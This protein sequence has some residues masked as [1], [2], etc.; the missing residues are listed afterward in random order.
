MP[1]L[2]LRPRVHDLTEA[3]LGHLRRAN[4]YRC[5][6]CGWPRPGQGMGGAECRCE[7]ADT[8]TRDRLARLHEPSPDRVGIFLS[9]HGDW[10]GWC[11]V[12]LIV[13]AVSFVAGVLWG[14]S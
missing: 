4:G 7:G 3:R 2:R 12:F 11:L 8:E 1:T 14:W 5:L 9:R 13:A 10:L 6:L